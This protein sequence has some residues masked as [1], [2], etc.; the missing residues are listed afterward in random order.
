VKV[1]TITGTWLNGFTKIERP[2]RVNQ[3]F[4]AAGENGW[5]IRVKGMH[6]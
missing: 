1:I 5:E 4:K 2:V 6:W 3:V